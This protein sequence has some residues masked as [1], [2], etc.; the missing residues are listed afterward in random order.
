MTAKIS[1][2]HRAAFLAEINQDD[3]QRYHAQEKSKAPIGNLEGIDDWHVT[4][5]I[6][7]NDVRTE[8][9]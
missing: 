9:N 4:Q 2:I 3:D 6:P 1:K 8:E 7:R 5:E